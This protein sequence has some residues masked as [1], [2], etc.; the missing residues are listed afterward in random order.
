MHG[1]RVGS[2]DT[3]FYTTVTI[4]ILMLRTGVV[5]TKYF[6]YLV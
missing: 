3:Y 6:V 4:E 5:E 1:K 2:D